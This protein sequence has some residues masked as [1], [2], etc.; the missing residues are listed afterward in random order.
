MKLDIN[1]YPGSKG[2]SG[3]TQWI[4]NHIPECTFFVEA[5]AVSGKIGIELVKNGCTSDIIFNEKYQPVFTQLEQLLADKYPIN[6]PPYP[7]YKINFLDSIDFYIEKCKNGSVYD[8]SVFYFDPPYLLHSRKSK[9]NIYG[10]EWSERDHGAFLY[11]VAL[12]C[13]SGAKIIISHYDCEMYREALTDWKTDTM[14]T[15]TR[16]GEAT[17]KIWM[18]YDI[19]QLNLL[20]TKFVGTDYSDRQRITRRKK[21]YANKFKNMP[22][23]ERQAILE[24]IQKSL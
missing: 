19:T 6:K 15:M 21:A 13:E 10:S 11:L 23:H 17:E 18:N 14:K 2:G 4:I 5:F 16:G 3:V 20:C 9:R 12:L 8:S 7:R 1:N 22:L 24:H